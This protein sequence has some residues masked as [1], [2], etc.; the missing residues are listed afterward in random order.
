MSARAEMTTRGGDIVCRVITDRESVAFTLTPLEALAFS[1]ALAEYGRKTLHTHASK[2]LA[3]MRAL[4]GEVE[5]RTGA[6]A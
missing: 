5:K 2:E 3:A 6:V 1:N 4:L